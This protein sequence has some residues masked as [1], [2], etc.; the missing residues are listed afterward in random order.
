MTSRA[1]TIRVGLFALAALVL[2]AI[3][4]IVFGGL[5]V[6]EPS[7]RYRIVF[8]RSVYGLESGAR[9][10]LNGVKVGTVD[11]VDVAPE[12]IRSVVVAIKVERGTPVRSDTR[13]VLQ[14]SGLTGLK[15]IDLRDGTSASPALPPGSQIA[16]GASLL[17]RLEAQAQTLVDESS[18][19]VQRVNALTGRMIA[20]TE[21]A[22]RAADNLAQMSAVLAATVDENRAVLRSSFAAFQRAATGASKLIDG[23]AAQLF[24]NADEL[25]AGLKKLVADNE[26]TLRSAVLDF[27][28]ASRSLKELTRE[29]RQRPSRLLYSGAAPDRK[30]P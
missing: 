6:W 11:T 29:V 25:V 24:G 9:V 17:D 22:Q 14:S 4:L 27:R 3:V 8:A 10:Y 21:P 1:Q 19:L 13:A 2:V 23:P 20:V 15:V 16:A 18:S 5:T 7:D 12:D 30:L 26:A 28:Q